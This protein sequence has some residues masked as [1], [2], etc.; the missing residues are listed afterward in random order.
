MTENEYARLLRT[1]EA[2]AIIKKL[3]HG[4]IYVLDVVLFA[5]H[6]GL[7]RGEI[8]NLR[9]KAVD[10]DTWFLTVASEAGAETKSGHERRVFLVGPARTVIERLF[11]V[12]ASEEND[13]VFKGASGAQ[14][15]GQHISKRF[16]F[17]RRMAGLGEEI[18]FHNLRHTF[19]SWFAQRGGDMFKLKEIMGHSDIEMTMIYAHLRPQDIK[20]EMQKVFGGDREPSTESY[21]RPIGHPAPGISAA[22]FLDSGEDT[23]AGI[24]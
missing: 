14:L 20:D 21:E 17:Y 8:C 9:W 4:N 23:Q 2:D 5:A 10:L 18:H 11:R 24:S 16:R 1:I 3:E 7:R 19:A 15:N 6:T 13:Y 12:R 22:V